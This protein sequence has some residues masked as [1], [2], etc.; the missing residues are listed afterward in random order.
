MAMTRQYLFAFE[1]RHAARGYVVRLVRE[2]RHLAIFI[3]DCH[4]MVIDGGEEERRE[5]ILQL[6]RISAARRLIR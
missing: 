5:R 4:V 1:D 6:A 2:L 3:D